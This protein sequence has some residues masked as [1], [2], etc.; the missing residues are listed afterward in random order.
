MIDNKQVLNWQK[1]TNS[2]KMKQFDSIID[3]KLKQNM[4]VIVTES[5]LLTEY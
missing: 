2:N 3:C 4:D 1:I 5:V